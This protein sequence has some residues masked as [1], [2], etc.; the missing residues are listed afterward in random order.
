MEWMKVLQ[1]SANQDIDNVLS[2]ASGLSLSKH[3]YH[4]S[5]IHS[6]LSEQRHQHGGSLS[7]EH[8]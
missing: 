6:L 4:I 8:K 2:L 1:N 7:R 3:L 5:P